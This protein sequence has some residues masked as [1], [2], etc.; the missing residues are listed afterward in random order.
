MIHF[1]VNQRLWLST[2]KKFGPAFLQAMLSPAPGH[3]RCNSSVITPVIGPNN[4]N[5]PAL[6]AFFAHDYPRPCTA[7]VYYDDTQCR[8]TIPPPQIASSHF[9][10]NR[11]RR[12][13]MK[14]LLLA[15][16]LIPGAAFAEGNETTTCSINGQTR[17][18]EVTHSDQG[19][20]VHYTKGSETKTVWSSSHAEY[21]LQQA[22]AFIEKQKGW[23]YKCAADAADAAPAA[24]AATAP[25]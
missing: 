7:V 13:A 8:E 12:T 11:P 1:N 18:V 25:Q 19:C 4:I 17:V 20:E 21:C 22:T 15:L 14:K 16:L 3:I 23:G 5:Q 2:P 24:A 9:I 10:N 6:A